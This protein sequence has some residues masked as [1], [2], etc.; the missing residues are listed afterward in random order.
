M[1]AF[2]VLTFSRSG[3]EKLNP[4]RENVR[5][6]NPGYE[7]HAIFR[8]RFI[9]AIYVSKEYMNFLILLNVNRFTGIAP[10]TDPSPEALWEAP[11]AHPSP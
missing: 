3:P 5:I 4:E 1:S 8:K 2:G 7:N 10:T 11:A 9:C 6:P